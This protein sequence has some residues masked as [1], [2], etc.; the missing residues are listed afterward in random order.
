MKLVSPV[1]PDDHALGSDKAS[2][3]LVEYGDYQC[4][5]CGRAHVVVGAI[6]EHFGPK[7]RF[8][9]R[10]MPLTHAHRYAELAARAAEASALQA[11][12]WEMH[13]LLFENQRQLGPELVLELARR[14]KLDLDKLEA[15]INNDRLIERIAGDVDS[16]LQS[17]VEGTPTFYINGTRHD[18]S[19]DE[20][21]LRKAIE[22]ASRKRISRR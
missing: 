6:R 19:Y 20:E 21:T 7:L 16:G 15:D 13:D 17:G 3:T 14:L 9:F 22:R 2:V 8:V 4:P 12:F 1:S 18:D 5:D 11:R 10:N